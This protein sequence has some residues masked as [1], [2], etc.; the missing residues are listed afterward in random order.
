M[1]DNIKVLESL[2]LKVS[3]YIKTSLDLVKLKALDKATDVVSSFI[4]FSV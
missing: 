3:D 2:L 1:E 4:P